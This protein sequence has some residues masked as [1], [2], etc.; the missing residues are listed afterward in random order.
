[1]RVCGLVTSL[2]NRD[3]RFV[4]VMSLERRR[5]W[6]RHLSHCTSSDCA[7]STTSIFSKKDSAAES[8]PR[9]RHSRS[10]PILP[11]TRRK[12]VPREAHVMY[13]HCIPYDTT[14]NHI[15]YLPVLPDSRSCR[16]ANESAYVFECSSVESSDSDGRYCCMSFAN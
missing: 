2:V 12:F 16:T 11:Q 5:R 8:R 15:F 7:L 6:W 10:Q 13:A 3:A 4:T 9:A 14:H 1:M